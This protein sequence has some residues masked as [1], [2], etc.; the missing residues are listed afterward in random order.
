MRVLVA[1]SNGYFGCSVAPTLFEGGHDT[2]GHADV[3][4][5]WKER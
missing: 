3:R 4:L 5:F 2:V 1:D